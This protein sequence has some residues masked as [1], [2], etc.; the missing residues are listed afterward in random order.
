MRTGHN[1]E[2]ISCTQH[3]S[4]NGNELNHLFDMKQDIIFLCVNDTL[5][6]A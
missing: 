3:K 1:R 5:E 4:V 2:I 6:S